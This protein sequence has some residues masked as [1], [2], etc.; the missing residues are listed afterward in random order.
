MN[1]KSLKHLIVIAVTTGTFALSANAVASEWNYVGSGFYDFGDGGFYL[2]GSTHVAERL[3]INAE[4]GDTYDTTVRVG[5]KYL[6]DLALGNAPMFVTAGYS[7]Y[8]FDTGVYFGAGVSLE[9]DQGI[10]STFELLHDTALDGFFRFR[11]GL[12]YALSN[13]LNLA[14]SY[15]INNRGFDNELRLG[16]RYKF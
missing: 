12:T 8:S 9:I 1:T 10:N 2:E 7:D 6:T 15:S 5:G 11:S 14:G 13:E 16:V 3:V 4:I